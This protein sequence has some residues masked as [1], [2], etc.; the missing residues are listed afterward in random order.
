M[1]IQDEFD[2]THGNPVVDFDFFNCDGGILDTTPQRNQQV[3]GQIALMLL[4]KTC[5]DT[6][7][8][9]TEFEETPWYTTAGTGGSGMNMAC[10]TQAHQRAILASHFADYSQFRYESCYLG[11]ADY[12]CLCTLLEDLEDYGLQ[13]M[14]KRQLDANISLLTRVIAEFADLYAKEDPE[15]MFEYIKK[16]AE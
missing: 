5:Q 8:W 2:R 14:R 12:R 4:T 6:L 15:F 16:V 13:G 7:Q 11:L 1:N 9:T 3:A 10:M